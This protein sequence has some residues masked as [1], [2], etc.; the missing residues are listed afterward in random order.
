MTDQKRKLSKKE[1]AKAM[2]RVAALTFRAAPLAVVIKLIGA[3]VTAT[4]PL[5]TTFYAAL[6]TT[7]L[8]EAYAGDETAGGRAI[9]FVLITAALGIAMT[10]WSSLER[11]IDQLTRYKV[12]VA[13]NDQLYSQF[14]NLEFWQYDDKKTMDLFDRAKQ[15]AGMFPYTFDRIAG[16]ITQFF[17]MVAGIVALVFVSWWLGLIVLLAVI[18]SMVI[19]IKLSRLQNAHWTANIESRRVKNII[20]WTLFEQKH[21]AEV[22]LYGVIRHLL[23]TRA[24]LRDS[25]EKQRIEF[26]RGFI[27]KRLGGDVLEAAAEITALLYTTLQIIAHAQPIGQFLYVQQVVSRA[28]GGARGFVGQISQIDEDMAY[29]FDYQEFMQMPVTTVNQRA[30]D[31]PPGEVSLKNVSFTYPGAKRRTLHGVSMTIKR[32]QH[33]AIV[34]E[35]GAGKSTL[36]KLITGLYRPT[37]GKITLDDVDMHT[38]DIASWHAQLGVLQQDFVQ[39]EFATARENVT[40]G[41]VNTPYSKQRFADALDRAEAA[42][43]T[44]KLPKGIDNYVLNWMEHSDGTKGVNLS[45]GQWQRLALARNF[46]RDSPI[47]ILDEP[48]SAIDALAESRIFKRL[49]NDKDRTVI[50]I[51][52]RVTTIERADVIYMLKDG[53][54]VEQGTHAELVAV[55]GPYFTMFESQ[56]HS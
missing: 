11:Y 7:A 10:A 53:K 50:T 12:D 41:D 24:K 5:V 46:Y 40:L 4:L 54:V 26:E 35:N 32:G 21:I 25:D 23:D 15:F 33:V 48:T 56:L 37:E 49:F 34:G 51:S 19:Q 18:P 16:L 44:A 9:M 55:R 39:Y 31:T 6:T 30:L 8:A 36:I 29:L 42:D 17:T 43:F 45:G 47:I 38:I 2:V 1:S 28:L 14:L 20:E 13:V 22:R 3:L 27:L 52:H